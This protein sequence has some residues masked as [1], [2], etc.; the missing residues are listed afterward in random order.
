MDG[1]MFVIYLIVK[2]SSGEYLLY[3]EVSLVKVY[4]IAN[5]PM[6]NVYHI[7]N[8]PEEGLLYGT[9]TI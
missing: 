9:L 2:I 8:I 3:G 4:N 1:G 7:L 5:I 6:D